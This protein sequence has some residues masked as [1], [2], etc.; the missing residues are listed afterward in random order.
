MLDDDIPS[1]DNVHPF[2]K[3]ENKEKKNKK[4][5]K[6]Y[7][8]P[9][10]SVWGNSEGEILDNEFHRLL[11]LKNATL[12]EAL[13]EINR[14]GDYKEY[15]D[16]FK[17]EPFKL[18]DRAIRNSYER[19]FKKQRKKAFEHIKSIIQYNGAT[20]IID[21]VSAIQKL[22]TPVLVN[23]KQ[24]EIIAYGLAHWMWQVKRRL[25]G[26][27][28]ENH[29]VVGFINEGLDENGQG[30][31]KTTFAKN[32]CKPFTNSYDHKF[33]QHLF[34]DT[35]LD[36]LS[37]KKAWSDILS[38]L[39]AFLD[40]I[41]PE[42]KQ[43]VATL[44]SI[45][46]CNGTKSARGCYEKGLTSTE[47]L[48]SAMFT[49]NSDNFGEVIKD[50]TGNRRYLPIHVQSFKGK[51]AKDLDFVTFWQMI[52]HKLPCFVDM[53]M[54]RDLQQQHMTKSPFD[55]LV[56]LYGIESWKSAASGD[57]HYIY[58]RDIKLV[59]NKHFPKE[60]NFST[61]I[62]TKELAKRGFLFDPKGGPRKKDLVYFFKFSGNSFERWQQNFSEK[63]SDNPD[64]RAPL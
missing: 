33:E 49:C 26:L 37:D 30:S 56:D 11:E 58:P 59:L 13:E 63:E 47:V 51:I 64:R 31:G 57:C 29:L 15:W 19:H 42:S 52:D 40:D 41:S 60:K 9:K 38:R 3:K 7:V 8:F 39:I 54:F 12:P 61:Q 44:K 25:Y 32:I 20:Q 34:A 4:Q 45:F 27:E 21:A 24:A 62:V 5:E 46:T 10:H 50:V 16:S 36:T 2:P 17:K 55:L 1:I 18:T 48:V 14:K 6:E 43:E 22:I 35:D 53:R 23:P 28:V